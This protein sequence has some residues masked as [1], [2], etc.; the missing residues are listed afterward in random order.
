MDATAELLKINVDKADDEYSNERKEVVKF[1]RKCRE[2]G[3][4]FEL[5]RRNVIHEEDKE[6][7]GE[8]TTSSTLQRFNEKLKKKEQ[9]RLQRMNKSLCEESSP[10][11]TEICPPKRISQSGVF[12]SE[13]DNSLEDHCEVIESFPSTSSNSEGDSK[14]SSHV[15]DNQ[16]NG[17][18]GIGSVYGVPFQSTETFSDA[19]DYEGNNLGEDDSTFL[20]MDSDNAVE[21]VDLAD[22]NDVNAFNSSYVDT[23]TGVRTSSDSSG[24]VPSLLF[25]KTTAWLVD[26]VGPRPSKRKRPAKQTKL[27]GG[28]VEQKKRGSTASIPRPALNHMKSKA[29]ATSRPIPGLSLTK[30]KTSQQKQVRLAVSKE[31]RTHQ[32]AFSVPNST[33]NIVS[34]PVTG[35]PNVVSTVTAGNSKTN[36]PETYAQPNVALGGTPPMRL[37]VRVQDKVFLIP[38]PR[39]NLQE[40][41]N[42]GWLAEQVISISVS[43]S[44]CL[45]TL[46]L[47]VFTPWKS[48]ALTSCY[49]E[50]FSIK[51]R[52]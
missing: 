30:S 36:T 32:T 8:E 12:I 28:S 34:T 5:K 27:T 47:V 51:C 10:E 35:R 25:E 4:C 29:S 48:S 6:D 11:D 7:D 41:K 22:E 15:L 46:K 44:F 2:K 21:M 14:S 18:Q 26:D 23:V 19:S 17:L 16:P 13:N 39:S 42:I 50:Q 1:L 9:E 40:S 33:V 24:Q 49:L 45:F 31:P 37:R 20:S 3:G 52:K 43:F 38:C